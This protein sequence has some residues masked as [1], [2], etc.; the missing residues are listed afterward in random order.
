MIS[1]PFDPLRALSRAGVARPRPIDPTGVDGPTRAQARSKRWRRSSRGLYVPVDDYPD[2]VAQRIVEAAAILPPDSAVTGWAALHWSGADYF[3]GLRA[4]GTL[5][6]VPLAVSNHAVRPQPGSRISAERLPPRDLIDV[7]GMPLT[8]H[9]RS[10]AFEM[11]R[12]PSLVAAVRVLDM[13]AAADLVSLEEMLAYT[14]AELSGWTGVE[15][16]RAAIGW[17]DENC[18]SPMETE[19]RLLWT[20][21]LHLRPV[22]N[23]PVFDRDGHFIAT[24]DLLDEDAGV[25]GEYDG[26]VHLD[27]D[28]RSQDISREAALR[29]VGLE[30]VT[31]TASDRRD[32]RPYLQRVREA[33]SRARVLKPAERAWTIDPPP[34]WTPT[35]T[36]EQRRA[37]D[38]WQKARYLHRR[39]A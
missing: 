2:G 6:D 15:Q 17:A 29:G 36:V 1:E 31:M 9:V 38:D 5:L 35:D 13:A 3:G 33:R 32:V 10:V 26:D 23:R 14:S 19:M 16:L 18:W 27:R 28:Q 24:P 22:R 20:S 25:C 11:R 30:V 12:A 21:Q 37:L 8:R 34:W 4:D 7:D 39:A